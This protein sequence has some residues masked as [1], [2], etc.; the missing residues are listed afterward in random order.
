VRFGICVYAV[1]LAQELGRPEIKVLADLFHMT[2][3]GEPVGAITEAGERLYHVH[4]PVP[5]IPGLSEPRNITTRLP[6]FPNRE[7]LEE[8]WGMNYKHRV[9]VEDLDRRFMNLERE[10]PL[11]LSHL[12][13]TWESFSM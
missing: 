5:D 3:E 6:T 4:M 9:S 2:V 12:K 11:V 1:A 13:A 8:L 10:A 7:L